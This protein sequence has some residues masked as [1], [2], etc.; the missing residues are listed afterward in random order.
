[1]RRKERNRRRRVRSCFA[2]I[3][4]EQMC[5]FEFSRKPGFF[6]FVRVRWTKGLYGFNF[7]RFKLFLSHLS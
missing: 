5:I 7:N 3:F 2:R 1:M 6:N 4:Y